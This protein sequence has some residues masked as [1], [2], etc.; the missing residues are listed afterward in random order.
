MNQRTCNQITED[1]VSIRDR[2][3]M[4]RDDRDALAEAANRIQ[5]QDKAIKRAFAAVDEFE[6]PVRKAIA[7]ALM[8]HEVPS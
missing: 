1:L 6:L 2:I 7:L 5:A 3:S 8:G 4:S